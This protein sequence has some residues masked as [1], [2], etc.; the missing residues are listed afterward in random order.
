[1]KNILIINGHPDQKSLCTQ[2]AK[3]Y[4]K[5]AI[6]SGS[7]CKLTHLSDLH[8]DPILHYG[9]RKRTELEPDLLVVQEAIKQADHL[10]FVYPT[11]WG[12]YPALLKGFVDRIFLPGYAFKYKENSLLWNKL[13]K[14]KSAHL[15]VTMDTPKWYYKLIYHSPGHNSLKN[16][17]LKFC[18][19]K[20]VKITTFAPVKTASPQKIEKWISKVEKIGSQIAKHG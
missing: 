5:G 14:G 2:L 7:E 9:Y 19:V 15:L 18:G 6:D 20:P 17:I 13:L 10:V 4:L 3:S 12:T 16:G 8:F 1:M 11:W